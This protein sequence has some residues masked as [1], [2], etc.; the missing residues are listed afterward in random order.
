[1]RQWKGVVDGVVYLHDRS[2]SIVHGDLKPVRASTSTSLVLDPPQTQG[3]VL[4]DDA[5]KPKIC[6]FGLARILETISGS[7]LTTTSEHTGTTR[8]L[9]P[10]LVTSEES[11]PPTLASDLYAL[12]CLGLEVGG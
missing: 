9:A 11:V 1:M 2:P 10:E 12:G 5:G 8:Y 3:N 6:D 4:I 7:G